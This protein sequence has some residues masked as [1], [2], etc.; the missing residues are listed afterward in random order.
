VLN[1]FRSEQDAF[2]FLLYVG[3]VV[4]AVVLLVVIVR[5]IF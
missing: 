1:P 2:R 3:G 4:L 5:A